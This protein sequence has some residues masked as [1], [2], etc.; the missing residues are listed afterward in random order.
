MPEELGRILP[1]RK[2]GEERFRK[3]EDELAFDLKD[4]W[5]W[6]Y[7]DLV[8]NATRG[9]LAE[10]IVARALGLAENDVRDE[11]APFD[12][13]T[14]EGVKV[15]VKSA[16]Y[17]QSWHQKKLSVISFV[18]PKT[19]GWDPDTGEFGQTPRRKA[20]VYVFAL[21]AHRDKA[22]VDPMDLNQWEF[23]VLPT[24]VLD[25]RQRSQHS[26]TLPSLQRLVQPVGFARLAEAVRKE[27]GD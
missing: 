9:V 5:R 4:F 13:C 22:T 27:S 24:K 8:S 12:L 1:Q 17:V 14:D 3:G 2:T 15:E 25:E 23:Y 26:I 16:A 19:R 6:S 10:F 11:W 20:D 18:V 21:L 7:S